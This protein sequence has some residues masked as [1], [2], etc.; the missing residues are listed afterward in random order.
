M[1]VQIAIAAIHCDYRGL[2]ESLNIPPR[3]GPTEAADQVGYSFYR[4]GWKSVQKSWE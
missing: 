1:H 3:A 2:Y 4:E